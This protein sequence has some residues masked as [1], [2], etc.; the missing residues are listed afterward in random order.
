MPDHHEGD[1]ARIQLR[2][3]SSTAYVSLVRTAAAAI[4]ARLDYSIDRIDDLRLAVDE[5]CALVIADAADDAV[6]VC[7]FVSASTQLEVEIAGASR[8]GSPPS[9]GSFAWTVLSALVDSVSATVTNERN[10]II[11]LSMNSTNAASTNEFA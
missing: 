7:E 1:A 6:I 10:L 2:I 8:S 4:A 5:A 11:R 3:P 9:S